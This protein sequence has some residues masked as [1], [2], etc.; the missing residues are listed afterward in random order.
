LRQNRFTAT[1]LLSDGAEPSYANL[2]LS[3]VG[4]R[5]RRGLAR[6]AGLAVGR[7]IQL[8]RHL[9]SSA[10]GIYALGGCAEVQELVLPYVLPTMQAAR[11]LA[12]TLSGE[13]TERVYPAMPAVVKTPV[14]ATVVAPPMGDRQGEWG[15]ERTEAGVR[16][17]FRDSAGELCGFALCGDAVAEKQA[18]TPRLRRWL[19]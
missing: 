16:A 18:L 8:N 9:V 5:P 12:R 10:A 7:G 1:R 6:R 3:A 13:L 19:G 2:V 14:F 11:A 17:L 15:V 4:L